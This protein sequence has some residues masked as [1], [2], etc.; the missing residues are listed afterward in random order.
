MCYVSYYSYGV[1]ECIPCNIKS[2]K[3]EDLMRR[4][5]DSV[6]ESWEMEEEYYSNKKGISSSEYREEYRKRAIEKECIKEAFRM[7]DEYYKKGG[8]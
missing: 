7:E 8:K 5:D 4:I 6:Y 1:F 2:N 3:E